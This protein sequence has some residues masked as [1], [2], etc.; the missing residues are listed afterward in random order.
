MNFV[1]LAML[2][3]TYGVAQTCQNSLQVPVLV[4]KALGKIL[5]YSLE[6]LGYFFT[7][8]SGQISHMGSSLTNSVPGV[9]VP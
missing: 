8:P 1:T 6:N 2:L 7:K 4:I 3:G 5:G 9:G